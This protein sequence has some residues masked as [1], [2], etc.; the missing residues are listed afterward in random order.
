MKLTKQRLKQIIKEELERVSEGSEMN[1]WDEVD[2][3]A[4]LNGRQRRGLSPLL[5]RITGVRMADD[6]DIIVSYDVGGVDEEIYLKP[7]GASPEV[8]DFE[9]Y[10]NP[11][12]RESKRRKR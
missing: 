8:G 2:H 6:G 10:Q 12:I 3:Q 1:R 7:G 5:D 4:L 9:P 11:N